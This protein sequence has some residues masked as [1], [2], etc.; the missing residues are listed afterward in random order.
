MAMRRAGHAIGKFL[1]A[2]LAGT[3]KAGATGGLIYFGQ[4]ALTSKVNFLQAHPLAGPI[5]MVAAGH[6]AKKKFPTVGTAA[7]GAGTYAL[8]L[9]YDLNKTAKA[10]AAPAA[11]TNAL[12]EPQDV[13]ALVQPLDI[14]GLPTGLDDP[15]APQL[16]IEDAMNLGARGGF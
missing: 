5:G 11:G 1:G 16:D 3:A 13:G 8:A 9:A 12:V 10:N 4:K 2:G 15:S 6:L 14:R 7:I